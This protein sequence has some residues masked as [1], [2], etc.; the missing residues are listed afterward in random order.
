MQRVAYPYTMLVSNPSMNII[1]PFLDLVTCT[2]SAL[3]EMINC[4][5]NAKLGRGVQVC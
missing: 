2:S 5:D 1:K 3:L 4:V